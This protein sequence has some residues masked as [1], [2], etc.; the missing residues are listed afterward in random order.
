M[1]NVNTFAES[2]IAIGYESRSSFA[3]TNKQGTMKPL[4]S[5]RLA[6]VISNSDALFKEYSSEL[7]G[8]KEEESTH[9][10]SIIKTTMKKKEPV[11]IQGDGLYQ[12]NQISTKSC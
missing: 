5:P 8:K 6:K 10:K 9:T 11:C 3:A 1:I 7:K 2:F 4:I 12:L